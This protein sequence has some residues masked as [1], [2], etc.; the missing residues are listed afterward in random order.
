MFIP[1]IIQQVQLN[2]SGYF[3]LIP[4]NVNTRPSE[5]GLR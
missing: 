3:V 4:E 2:S 5:L 1:Q